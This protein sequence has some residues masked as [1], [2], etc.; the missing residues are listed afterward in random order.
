MNAPSPHGPACVTPGLSVP[1]PFA[2]YWLAQ[3]NLRL[4]REIA[5]AWH[6]RAGA[7]DPRDGSLPTETDPAGDALDWVRFAT[8]RERFQQ[9]DPAAAYL[10]DC[11]ARLPRPALAGGAWA[12]VADAA[13]LDEA[14]TFVLAMAMAQHLDA[15]LGPVFAACANDAT[16]P[17]P[18]PALAQRL[19]D[20]PA[21]VAC[22][23]TEDHPLFRL[24]LLR[25]GSGGGLGWQM[26]LDIAPAVA[27]ALAGLR[28]DD[29]ARPH[30]TVPAHVRLDGVPAALA[31]RLARGRPEGLE[32]VAL[33]GPEAADH[34][35]WA[36]AL[37]APSD[38]ALHPVSR[39]ALA[40]PETL[41]TR[42]LLAWIDGADL[43]LPAPAEEDYPA[44]AIAARRSLALPIR[45]FLPAPQGG[46]HGHR[47]ALPCTARF[48]VSLPPLDHAARLAMLVDGLGA[49]AERLRPA[50]EDCARRFRLEAPAV[51][52][53]AAD[54]RGRPDLD[55]GHVADACRA[56]S[57]ARDDGATQRVTPRFTGAE[58]VLPPRQM[59]QYVEIRDAMRA[60]TEVHYRWGTAQ[61]WSEAGLSVLFCG[62]P[63][64][65]KTMAAE[66]LASDL[67]LDLYRTDLSQVVN[68]YIGETEKNLRRVFDAA[69]A[70][71]AILFF[72]EADALF[73]KRT[74]VKDAH[75]RFANIE[76]S[77]LLER[78]ERFR[79]LAILA[80][81]RRKDLDEAFMRRLRQVLEFPMPGPEERE[82]IWRAAIPPNVDATALEFGFLA[83]Q[84]TFS[85]GHIRSVL[86]NAC[87][88]AAGRPPEAPLPAGKA[89]RLTMRDVLVQVR[90]ELDKLNRTVGEEQ[91][92]RYAAQMAEWLS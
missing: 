30:V 18:T 71:D 59:R 51:R 88:Q 29:P 46:G 90:R 85:G 9:D 77:Y 21:A 65:G 80:T 36:A 14:G 73:G 67:R 38:R 53:I 8:A 6:Q 61:A 41:C 44:L 72:D 35:G 27:Q 78:M 84:F 66:A 34:S 11:L 19:W 22:L 31:A 55:A 37:A 47:P 3:V 39:R 5:W 13:G 40:E 32:L 64:T 54:L 74:D 25:S 63:G 26:P 23:L 42:C 2:A 50:L 49:S 82:R 20:D 89:G 92:G 87:L 10:G 12:F 57:G 17:Y 28:A 60:L 52:R 1:D 58:L 43:M 56:A 75:D 16:R 45:W 15:G 79:G 24:G 62:P 7:A 91:F 48:D 68:K 76:I 83:R 4:R 70:S 33:H 69:E 86:L 81:N